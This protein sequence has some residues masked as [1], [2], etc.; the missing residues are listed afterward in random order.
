MERPVE[1]AV[2]DRLIPF[3]PEPGRIVANTIDTETGAVIW[4]LENGARVILQPTENRNDE[5]VLQAMARGGATSVSDNDNVSAMLA[6]EM[7]QVSGL[8]SWSLPDL[9]RQLAARQVS[10]ARSVTNYT[11]GFQ[12]SS[13]SRDLQTLFEMLYLNFT[14]PRIDGDAV[15]AMMARY[16]SSL[17][18][19]NENPRIVFNDEVN[20]TLTSDHPRFRPLELADLPSANIDSALAFL[21]RSLNPADFTFVFAGNLTPDL[22]APLVETYLASIPR[23]ETWNTWTDLNIVRPGRVENNVFRGL[24]EQSIVHMAWFAPATFT[25]QFSIVAQALT[26]YLNIRLNEE[27]R[28]NLGGVYGIGAGASVSPSPRGELSLQIQFACDPQ[29]VQELSDAVLNLLRETATG[30][31]TQSHFNNAIEAMHQGLEVS[32]QSNSFIAQSYVNSAVLLELPLS[33][34]QQRPQNFNA[35]TPAAIQR[36]MAQLLPNGPAKVVLFPGNSR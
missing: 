2:A 8:G 33:R 23:G 14:E 29:R 4:Q 13:T 32:M 36:M 22:M 11:R 24:E 3:S 5:I 27:I 26:E 10:L 28:D 7:M 15:E 35:V 16:R 9:S 18:L 34:L 6:G 31:I 20:R 19:R 1:R 21:R 30:N 12:G 17:A 25:E